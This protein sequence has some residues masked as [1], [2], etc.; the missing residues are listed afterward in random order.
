[1]HEK[2]VIGPNGA[3]P[4]FSTD[5]FSGLELVHLYNISFPRTKALRRD[6]LVSDT[7][8][9]VIWH[10]DRHHQANL[11]TPINSPFAPARVIH[12]SGD[13]QTRT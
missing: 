4:H 7:S 6:P 1:V 8:C 2:V 5:P 11:V 12:P 13:G 9:R 3:L 10:Y